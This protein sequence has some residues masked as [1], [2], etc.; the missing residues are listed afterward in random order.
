MELADSYRTKQ[1]EL[2]VKLKEVVNRLREVSGIE[3]G[4]NSTTGSGSGGLHKTAQQNRSI[5]QNYS[6]ST[7]VVTSSSSNAFGTNM[8]P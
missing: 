6:S 7:L 8:S 4:K 5:C 1:T 3:V 2:L